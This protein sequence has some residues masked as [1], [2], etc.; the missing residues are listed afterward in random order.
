[1]IQ[2][3]N[4]VKKEDNA[5]T[6]PSTALNQNESLNVYANAPTAP[7]AMVV[8]VCEAFNSSPTPTNIFRAK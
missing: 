1:M 4:A 7:A 3:T 8:K 5:Y 6:S 2:N